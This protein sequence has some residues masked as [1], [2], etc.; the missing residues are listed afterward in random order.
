MVDTKTQYHK[1]KK[2][3]DAAVLDV[4][5]SSMF[6]GGKVVTSFA[7]NLATYHGSKH[8]IPWY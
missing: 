2:E 6:I 3:V 8:C 4:L 5:E 1:I 7:E